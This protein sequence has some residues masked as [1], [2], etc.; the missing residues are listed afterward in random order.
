K[1][2]TTYEQQAE[3][4]L[5]GK[6]EVARESQKRSDYYLKAIKARAAGKEAD[7]AGL[8]TKGN[9]AGRESERLAKEEFSSLSSLETKKTRLSEEI[10]AEIPLQQEILLPLEFSDSKLEDEMT[11]SDS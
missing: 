2:A 5:Q 4:L 6:E 9:D 11:G 1:V 10:N 8:E 3:A 7:A